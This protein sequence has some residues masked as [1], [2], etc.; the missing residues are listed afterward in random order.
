MRRGGQVLHLKLRNAYRI[1][2]GKPEI[3]REHFEYKGEG[4]R[5]ILNII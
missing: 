1:L 5:V 4:G 2:V 3:K